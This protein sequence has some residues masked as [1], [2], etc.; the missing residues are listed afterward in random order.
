MAA[1]AFYRF[2]DLICMHP[3]LISGVAELPTFL[4]FEMNST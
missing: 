3:P 1:T 2:S 4:N